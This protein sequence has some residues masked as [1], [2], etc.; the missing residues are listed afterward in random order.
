MHII[1]RKALRDFWDLH[2]AS[3]VPLSRWYTIVRKT[4]FQDLDDLRK[5]FPS[6]DWVGGLVVFNIGG[7][8][9][10]LIAAVHFNRKRIYIRNVLTHKEYD[11]GAW[12]P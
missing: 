11:Q 1:S 3:Q 2:P 10:R 9:Y 12:K 5:T 8:S 4:D 6:A 7:N